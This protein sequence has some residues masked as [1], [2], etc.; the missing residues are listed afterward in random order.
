MKC[1]RILLLLC[2][3]LLLGGCAAEEA[4]ETTSAATVAETTLPVTVPTTEGKPQWDD[5]IH[6]GVREDGTFTAGTLFIGDSLTYGLVKSYLQAY[7]LIGQARYMSVVGA[8]LGRFF[9]G[10]TLGSDDSSHYS[11]EF[12]GLSY[13]EAVAKVGEEATAIYLMLG[14]N[15][16]SDTDT[17]HYIE[18][19]DYLLENCPNA[20][21][22]LQKIPLCGNENVDVSGVNV[23]LEETLA[24]YQNQGV[25]RVMLIDTFTVIGLSQG[26]DGIHLNAEGMD[27]WYLAIVANARN[28]DLPE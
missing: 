11:E 15:Y 18:V 28:N 9:S 21:V 10:Q 3:A 5:N 8:P 1:K 19:V 2:T 22:H 23:S 7:D 20:T 27:A 14:T 16:N 25:Q 6:S 24:H 26:Y 13:S 4:P 17:E 12:Y